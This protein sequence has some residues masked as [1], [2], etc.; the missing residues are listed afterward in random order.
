M[1]LFVHIDDNELGYLI[2][3]TDEIFGRANRISII[4]FKQSSSS[5][6]KAINPGI[7]TTNNFILF[8]VKSK[9]FWEPNRVFTAAKRDDRYSKFIVNFDSPFYEWRLIPLREAF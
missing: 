4:T 6:P 8:Y 2:A 5:G 1:G 9:E 3:L 7:A